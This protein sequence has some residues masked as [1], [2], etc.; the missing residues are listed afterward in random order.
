[1]S[2][3]AQVN[4]GDKINTRESTTLFMYRGGWDSLLSSALIIIN[5]FRRA[6][7]W[8]YNPGMS[9]WSVKTRRKR[10][11]LSEYRQ[12][13]KA[14]WWILI[15][16]LTVNIQSVPGEKAN[17]LWGHY[18]QESM[19]AHVSYSNGFRD[20]AISLYSSKIVDKKEILNVLSNAGIYC[21]SGKVGRVYLV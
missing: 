9:R 21:S 1:V 18:M 16:Y 20:T 11:G 14:N 15:Y 17:I 12:A 4:D 13:K 8:S 3:V 5:N 10:T 19:Y 7:N 6:T 2:L